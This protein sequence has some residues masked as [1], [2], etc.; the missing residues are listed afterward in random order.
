MVAEIRVSAAATVPKLSGE[1]EVG[2]VSIIVGDKIPGSVRVI[3][4]GTEG[5]AELDAREEYKVSELVVVTGVSVAED[6]VS[7]SA[8]MDEV[9]SRGNIEVG[10]SKGYKSS[11]FVMTGASGAGKLW[12]TGLVGHTVV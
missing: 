6:T 9:F 3:D 8:D 1:R 4:V 10:G 11:A 12:I 7:T 2:G 5:I